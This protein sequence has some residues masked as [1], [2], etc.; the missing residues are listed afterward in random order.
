MLCA[1]LRIVAASLLFGLFASG[2]GAQ[3]Q[4]FLQVVREPGFGGEAG[5]QVTADTASS[6]FGVSYSPTMIEV[7]VRSSNPAYVYSVL[8]YAPA[9]GVLGVGAYPNAV[10]NDSAVPGIFVVDSL[11]G[12]CPEAGAFTILDLTFANGLVS[13]F[14]ADF[15]VHCWGDEPSTYGGIRFNSAVPYVANAPSRLG[16]SFLQLSSTAGEPY[17]QGQQYMLTRNNGWFQTANNVVGATDFVFNPFPGSSYWSVRIGAANGQPLAIG[18]YNN[19]VPSADPSH[20]RLE[21][22]GPTGGGLCPVTP[23]GNFVVQDLQ[24]DPAGHITSA[25]VDFTLYCGTSVLNGGFRM[26]SAVPY[27]APALPPQPARVDRVDPASYLVPVNTVAGS[28]RV[29]VLDGSGNP[30]PGVVMTFTGPCV[31]GGP[32]NVTSDSNGVAQSPALATLSGDCVVQANVAGLLPALGTTFTFLTY[33]QSQVTVAAQP[34]QV[35]VNSGQS[36]LVGVNVEARGMPLPNQQVAFSLAAG[37]PSGATQSGLPATAVTDANGN[38]S[39]NVTAG[40]PTAHYSINAVLGSITASIAVTQQGTTTSPPL[41]PAPNPPAPI[42]GITFTTQDMWW[43]PGENG[44]GMS[45]VQHD[46]TLFGALYTYDANG[47]PTWV[48]LPGG[49]WDS[50]HTIYSGSVYRPAG[51]PFFAYN[52]ANLSVGGAVGTIS[53][54]FQDANDAILDYTIGGITGRKFVTREIFASGSTTVGNHSDLWWGGASQNGWGITVLQ[55]ADTLF[56]VWYTY[57]ATGNPT[58]YVM[59]GGTWTSPGTYEGKLYRTTSSSWIGS[60]YDASKLNVVEAGTFKFQFNGDNATFAYSADG[61]AGSIP[62]V[63]EPF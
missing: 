45:L 43:N 62:L 4:T 44:W 39:I 20:P 51:T 11:S 5:K 37:A 15:D 24:Y 25:A 53:L 35:T 56:A 1:C 47:K 26:N 29:R 52:A 40:L 63:K 33:S 59:P 61:H 21:F 30:L 12:L 49:A 6:T 36:Y 38:A 7:D 34:T 42:P 60:A 28:V 3:G 14:A 55:Q 16:P 31:G 54:T 17:A 10:E 13:S 18:T 19:A 8:F 32:A 23:T 57:D 58:W 9:N 27:S 2:A 48:V 22:T 50:T 41:P 46:D